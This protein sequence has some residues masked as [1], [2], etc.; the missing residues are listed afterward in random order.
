MQKYY[1]G[2]KQYLF[3]KSYLSL[4]T[5]SNTSI[6]KNINILYFKIFCISFPFIFYFNVQAKI[7]TVIG[8]RAFDLKLPFPKDFSKI[9]SFDVL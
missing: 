9:V 6:Y 5:I 3:I 4:Q 7:K 8:N 1:L 2:W